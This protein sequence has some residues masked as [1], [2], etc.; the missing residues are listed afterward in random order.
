MFYMKKVPGI[1]LIGLFILA[2]CASADEFSSTPAVGTASSQPTPTHVKVVPTPSSPGDSVIW[3]NL[4]VSMD[5]AEITD[6]FINEF[7]SQR[8]PS[9]GKKFLWIH[10]VL[11][12]VGTE[13]ILLPE[14]ENFSTLYAE[15]EFKPIYGHRQGYVD[16]TA[17]GSTLFPGQKLDAWL[18][19]DIPD[20]ADLEDLWFV[21]LP[22]SAQVGVLPS[23]PNYPYA[24]NK[25]TFVW[26]C[27]L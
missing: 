24:D 9:E 11:E 1:L 21:F 10:V 13:E 2:A 27:A 26:K 5:Q 19:F 14:P 25:P 4:Q 22:T 15:S 20:T 23:A 16:Y 12:N 7:G 6:S 3:R 8:I 18:R 17:L